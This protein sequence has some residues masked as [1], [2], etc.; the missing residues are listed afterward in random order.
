MYQIPLSLLF[1][2]GF[3]AVTL[4]ASRTAT[5]RVLEQC[6]LKIKR[7]ANGTMRNDP[8]TQDAIGHAEATLHTARPYLISSPRSN[9][10]G[11]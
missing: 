8:A 2:G 1:A 6:R 3:A 11:F 5:D 9:V 7:F 10:V 4:G